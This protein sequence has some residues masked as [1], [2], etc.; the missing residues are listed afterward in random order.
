MC[1]A[2]LRKASTHGTRAETC[3]E[4]IARSESTELELLERC[5][6]VAVQ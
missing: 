2:T 1:F 6:C 5:Q 3:K 4:G